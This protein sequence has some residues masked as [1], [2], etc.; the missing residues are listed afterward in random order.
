M[1]IGSKA[2]AEPRA[3]GLAPACQAVLNRQPPLTVVDLQHPRGGLLAGPRRHQAHAVDHVRDG[4]LDAQRNGSFRQPRRGRKVAVGQCWERH[5]L[6][7]AQ[8]SHGARGPGGLLV[9]TRDVPCELLLA[10]LDPFAVDEH[11][12][13]IAGAGGINRDLGRQA[14][15]VA[16]EVDTGFAGSLYRNRQ[17][18]RPKSHQGT[19]DPIRAQAS[20]HGKISSVRLGD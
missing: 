7:V 4:P 20:V 9:K 5:G 16:H 3:A 8:P 13:A 17:R 14:R 12:C 19:N 2:V 10:R 18:T 1:A 11:R 15:G 6:F